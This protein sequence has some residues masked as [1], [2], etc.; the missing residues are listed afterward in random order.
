MTYKE[1]IFHLRTFKEPQFRDTFTNPFAYIPRPECMEAA[2][3]VRNHI[4]TN[5]REWA[6]ELSKGKM[7]GVL[8]CK[9]IDGQTGFLAAFSGTLDGK[10][11]HEWFVPPIYDY[12]DEGGVFKTEESA[13]TELNKRISTIENCGEIANLKK[14][15]NDLTSRRDNEIAEAKSISAKRKQER[16]AE[17]ETHPER[18]EELD[19]QSQ[20]EKAEVKRLVRQWENKIKD[21]QS[22]IEDFKTEVDRLREERVRRSSILQRWLFS[23]QKVHNSHG[24]AKS[25]RDIFLRYTHTIPPSGTGE[26]CAPRLLNYAFRHNMAPISMAE[27]WV[28]ESPKG[29]IRIDG[30]FY[31]AC[32]RKCA[33]LL[34]WMLDGVG[35]D[36]RI[37]AFNT[38]DDT[39]EEKA[40]SITAEVSVVYEDEWILAVNKPAGLMTVSDRDD[41]D[42]LNKRILEKHP[43]ISGPGYVHRLDQPTSGIV[44]IAKDKQTHQKLQ[45]LFATRNVKKRYVAI[46]DGLPKSEKGVIELPLLPNIEDRPRQKIDFIRGKKA[47][48]KYEVISKEETATGKIRAMVYFYPMTGRTH[49]LRVHSASPLGLGCPIVGDNLY[50]HLD[51]RL[52][53]HADKIEFAHPVT[54]KLV[55]IICPPAF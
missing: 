20:H 33:P 16:K 3:I 55:T 52:M 40:P 41:I 35:L 42:S 45:H 25:V 36:T 11:R 53:L 15:L 13:I 50:G 1:P 32:Q 31:P 29:E 54:G 30:D 39:S 48:T 2:E 6:A 17:R 9:D 28:G 47:V 51:T 38:P 12:E 27:F 26:C 5:H 37:G 43:E 8:V 4:N 14:E 46:L 23:R 22:K 49:Q 7:L 21:I 19:R 18:C 24:E 10:L 34:R 44:L